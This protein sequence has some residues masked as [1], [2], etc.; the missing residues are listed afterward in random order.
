[1][2][3]GDIIVAVVTTDKERVLYSGAPVFYSKTKEEMERTALLLSKVTMGMIHDIENG[4]LVI[5]K[6]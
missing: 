4:C 3:Q 5:V 6:H 2:S 1:M